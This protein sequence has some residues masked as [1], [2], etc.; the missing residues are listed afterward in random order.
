MI[1]KT[2]VDIKHTFNIF[3][4]YMCDR[5]MQPNAVLQQNEIPND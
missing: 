5:N 1:F 3:N 2:Q 4:T